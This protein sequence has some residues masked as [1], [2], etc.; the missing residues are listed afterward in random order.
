M[1]KQGLL[2]EQDADLAADMYE[3]AGIELEKAGL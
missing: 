2:A 3:L 1:D